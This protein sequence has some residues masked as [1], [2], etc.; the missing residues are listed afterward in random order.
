MI[1]IIYFIIMWYYINLLYYIKLLY[2]IN[3]LDDVFN[4]FV[5]KTTTFNSSLF[6]GIESLLGMWVCVL[7]C[8]LYTYY[9][10]GMTMIDCI[11]SLIDSD[12]L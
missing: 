8:Y 7:L 3:L 12:T 5:E 11:D 2:D 4:L 9:V 10:I 1:I 6:K